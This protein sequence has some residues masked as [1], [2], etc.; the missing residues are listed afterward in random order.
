MKCPL[1]GNKNIKPVGIYYQ[2]QSGFD[3]NYNFISG[4]GYIGKK[5]EFVYKDLTKL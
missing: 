1:C 2:C 4:C 3:N 5:H